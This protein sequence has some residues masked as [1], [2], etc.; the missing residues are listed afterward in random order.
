MQGLMNLIMKQKR[1][2]KLLREAQ[3]KEGAQK[4]I[5][6]HGWKDRLFVHDD[7]IDGD[8][9]PDIVIRDR[10]NKPYVVRGYTTV[11][12]MAPYRAMYY[13][14]YPTAAERKAGGTFKK[15][16]DDVT[17]AQYDR[18]HLNRD[19]TNR[20]GTEGIKAFGQRGYKKIRLSE[21]VSIAQSFKYFFMKPIMSAVKEVI[22]QSPGVKLNLQPSYAAKLES[23]VRH[24]MFTLPVLRKVY[25][26]EVLQIADPAEFA[27]L[28]RSKDVRPYITMLYK[29]YL[30]GLKEDEFRNLVKYIV[31]GRLATDLNADGTTPV[32]EIAQGVNKGQLLAAIEA[33]AIQNYNL[34]GYKAPVKAE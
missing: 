15:F 24:N 18:Y 2:I 11:P 6:K 16:I 7:D 8:N 1:D 23:G 19:F 29:S 13:T 9:V 4:W 26:D 32:M 21:K 17:G 34:N 31:V 10:N 3:S 28:A 5:D 25:G 27:W 33:Q 30:D 14:E 12:S 22:K 20:P